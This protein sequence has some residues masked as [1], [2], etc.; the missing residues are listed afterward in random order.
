MIIAGT[1]HGFLIGDSGYGLRQYLLTPY[2]TPQTPQQQGYNNSLCQSRVKIEQTFGVLK[3]RFA[4]LNMLRVQ[5]R[6]GCQIVVVC[7]ML[8]NIG[9]ENADIMADVQVN[10][11]EN[12]MPPI[13]VL[14]QTAQLLRDRIAQEW[15]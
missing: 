11:E 6:K 13:A 10:V 15:F 12:D 9:I 8:H 14:G 3:R 5:P 7:A 2:R 4:C 1:H